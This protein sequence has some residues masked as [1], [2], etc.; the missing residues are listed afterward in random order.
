MTEIMHITSECLLVAIDVVTCP[1]QTYPVERSDTGCIDLAPV[2]AP[3]G[4][5]DFR[6]HPAASAPINLILANWAG[7]I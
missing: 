3:P 5:L 4:G 2:S 6:V 1:P 7:A